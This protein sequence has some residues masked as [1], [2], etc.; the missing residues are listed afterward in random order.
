MDSKDYK[1]TYAVSRIRAIEAKLLDRA[2]FDRM[3]D[4]RTPEEALKVLA[5]AGYGYTRSET[6]KA[7]DY[8]D[9]LKEEQKKVYDLLKKIAPEPEIFVLFLLKSDYHNVKAILK[10]EFSGQEAADFLMLDSGSIP[11][12]KMKAIVRDRKFTELPEIM[13]KA[14]EECIDAY[15]KTADPQVIDLILDKACYEHM[16]ELSC[17]HKNSFLKE[18]TAIMIDLANL[19]MFLRIKILGKPWELL[20]KILIPGGSIDSKLYKQGLEADMEHFSDAV[21]HTAYGSLVKE[22]IEGY[23][24]TGSLTKFEK[25]SD[26][27]IIN[28]I[29]K[30]KYIS[31]GIE[32]LVAY[33]LAKETEI[34]NARIV[35]VG[36]IN[37]IPNEVIRERL[38][39]AYV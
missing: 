24:S 6:G 22:S 21:L 32:P 18:L 12:D 8:E 39:E 35:M 2:K 28:Y 19:K 5:E 25:L 4:A 17:R 10:A 34:R 36:K 30:A 7:Y 11:P 9:M 38:R 33:L 31:F 23:R 1:Y 26:N 37:N 14:L 13:R 27:Y 15:N 20:Q 29:K 16:W 3:I